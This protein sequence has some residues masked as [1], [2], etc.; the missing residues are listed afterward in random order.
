MRWLVQLTAVLGLVATLGCQ[1]PV[2]PEPT[3]D[4]EATVT[5]AV[6]FDLGVQLL[7]SSE[8][9]NAI[10]AFTKA[11]AIDSRIADAYYFRGRAYFNLGQAQQAIQDYDDAIRLNP[12]FALAYSNRGFAYVNLGQLEKAIQDFGEAI[13]LNPNSAQA[14]AGRG[15]A[16][17]VLG[18]DAKARQDAD[19]AIEL[20]VDPA[21]LN[22]A[23]KE[24]R[25]NRSAP[26]S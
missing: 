13:R 4:I 14:H 10:K 5:A 20:G 1:Q 17:T 21:V 12:R 8:F 3:P 18:E 6:D 24:A 26:G 11:I 2:S 19:R 9:E 7:E 15:F 22:E 16:Y 25:S 23:I